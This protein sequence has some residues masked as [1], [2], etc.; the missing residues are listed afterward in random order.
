MLSI[1][2]IILFV[3]EGNKF[4]TRFKEGSLIIFTLPRVLCF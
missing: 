4:S 3:G 2:E 1:L